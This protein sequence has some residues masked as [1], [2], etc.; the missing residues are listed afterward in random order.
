MKDL[1]GLGQVTDMQTANKEIIDQI[2][3]ERKKLQ[4]RLAM[5]CKNPHGYDHQI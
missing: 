3:G 1:V 4:T 5:Q 2:K